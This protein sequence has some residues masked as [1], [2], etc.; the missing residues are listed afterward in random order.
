MCRCVLFFVGLKQNFHYT[1]ATI[2]IYVNIL[3]NYVNMHEIYVNMRII[4]GDI[5][6]IKLYFCIRVIFDSVINVLNINQLV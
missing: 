1:I 5:L 6:L 3:D 4:Y 2:L